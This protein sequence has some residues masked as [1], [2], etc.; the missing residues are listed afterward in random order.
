[1]SFLLNPGLADAVEAALGSVRI[2]NAGQELEGYYE[3]NVAADGSIRTR[4]KI[5]RRGETVLASCPF[6]N[7]QRSRLAVNHRFGVLDPQTGYRGT[8]LWKCYNE[9]CQHDP[10]NRRKLWDILN[11]LFPRRG[12]KTRPP[13]VRQVESGRLPPC[14]FPG[15]LI[16]LSD[17]PDDHVAVRYVRS[18]GYDPVELST[19]WRIGYAESVPARVRGSAAQGRLI[20]P[21][22]LDGVM[23]GYQARFIGELDWKAAGVA[24]YLT[25]FPKSQTLYGLDEAASATQIL[26]V[27]GVTDVWRYGPGAVSPLGKTLSFDQA[28]LLADGLKGRPLV[29]APDQDDPGSFD[30][31]CGNVRAVAEHAHKAGSTL[32]AGLAVIP[33]GKDPASLPRL[34]LRA[35]VDRALRTAQTM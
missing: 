29:V 6:C 2:M 33:V 15:L 24:K 13:E 30:A 22:H 35:R 14:E 9:E 31:F 19:I 20:C 10:N 18:R 4:L 8:E 16:P 12:F 21:V 7:D 11:P 28:K 26:L 32:T 25:Y 34:D 27:E 23:V 17:L 3:Q 5:V 1:M